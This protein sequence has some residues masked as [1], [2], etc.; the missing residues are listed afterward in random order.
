MKEVSRAWS[1]GGSGSWCEVQ[2]IIKGVKPREAAVKGSPGFGVRAK[3][4]RVS[5]GISAY[6]PGAWWQTG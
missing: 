3:R 2:K 6:R 5:N 4:R 1:G